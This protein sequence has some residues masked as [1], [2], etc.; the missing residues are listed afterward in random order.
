MVLGL[1][2]VTAQESSGQSAA[3]AGQAKQHPLDPA[4]LHQPMAE[5]LSG[6]TL[7]R[8]PPHPPLQLRLPVS[9]SVS[10][11]VGRTHGGSSRGALPKLDQSFPAI[12]VS[13]QTRLGLP[14]PFPLSL[15]PQV[16]PA[17]AKRQRRSG[18]ED[19]ERA[20]RRA[21]PPLQL[22]QAGALRARPGVQPA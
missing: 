18:S 16:W 2:A 1:P 12:Q 5:S 11:Q 10:L 22:L 15:N 21:P 20:A 17:G 13:L 4:M 7:G 6:T 8:S 19:L 9:V 14:T 3:L